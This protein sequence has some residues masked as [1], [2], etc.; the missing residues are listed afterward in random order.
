MPFESRLSQSGHIMSLFNISIE[1][2]SLSPEEAA[3]RIRD[4][5]V[6]RYFRSLE[7]ELSKAWPMQFFFVDGES[8]GPSRQIWTPGMR[9]TDAIR[10]TGGLPPT[11]DPTHVEIRYPGGA[12]QTCSLVDATNSPDKNPK[13][14]P[15][16]TILVH[17]KELSPWDRPRR[18]P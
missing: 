5:Y 11:A 3:S 16:A 17:A 12:T 9:L 6:P 15:G 7:V 2:A 1:L 14:S 13:I 18:T 10:V 8:K 4:A